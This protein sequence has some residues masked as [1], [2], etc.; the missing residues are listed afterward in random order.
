MQQVFTKAGRSS[1][2]PWFPKKKRKIKKFSENF[3]KQNF[4]KNAKHRDIKILKNI[5]LPVKIMQQ[6]IIQR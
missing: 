4:K 1:L 6:P 3:L 5:K 2:G